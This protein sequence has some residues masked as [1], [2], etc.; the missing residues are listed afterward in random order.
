M[1]FFK[2][3]VVKKGRSRDRNVMWSETLFVFNY[4]LLLLLQRLSA[5]V[6]GV[7]MTS[8]G[9]RKEHEDF[10]AAAAKPCTVALVVAKKCLHTVM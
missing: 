6:S 1:F 2:K 7:K 4:C 5:S 9:R 8:E 10:Y 3:T